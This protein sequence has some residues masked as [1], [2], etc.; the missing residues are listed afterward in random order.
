MPSN[1]GKPI[2]PAKLQ[3]YRLSPADVND[4]I[5]AQI[6]NQAAEADIRA[7]AMAE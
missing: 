3:G 2:D 1:E 4:A 5:R 7:A 6:H